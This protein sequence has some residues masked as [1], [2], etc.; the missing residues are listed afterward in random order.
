MRAKKSTVPHD[1]Q[2]VPKGAKAF[3]D[4]VR[5]F[6]TCASRTRTRPSAPLAAR[7]VHHPQVGILALLAHKLDLSTN[8]RNKQRQEQRKQNMNTFVIRQCAV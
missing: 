8:I 7:K 5:F 2:A 3:V 1:R 4:V 6:L